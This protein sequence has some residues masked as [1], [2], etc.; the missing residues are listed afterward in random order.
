MKTGAGMADSRRTEERN[1]G[2]VTWKT[3]Q[4]KTFLVTSA[5][6]YARQ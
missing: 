5:L 1:S 6:P 3:I 4:D 2:N